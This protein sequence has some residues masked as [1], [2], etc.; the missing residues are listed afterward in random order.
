VTLYLLAEPLGQTLEAFRALG[1]R[2]RAADRFHLHRRSHLSGAMEVSSMAA[3]PRA[4]VSA[5][6]VPY[7]PSTGAHVRLTREAAPPAASLL[8]VPG[9][10][11]AWTFTGMDMH[12][13]WCWLDDDPIAAGEAITSTAPAPPG[14][15]FDATLHTIDPRG[16]W[17]WFDC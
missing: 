5:E 3:A 2:L 15:L 1:Q 8:T 11:G 9:V 13:T 6:A 16:P 14:A 12:L 10:A 4:L 17:D 7:R